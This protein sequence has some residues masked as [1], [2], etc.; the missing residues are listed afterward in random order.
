MARKKN[1]YRI[2][3]VTLFILAAFSAMIFV[4]PPA[5]AADKPIQLK[6][7]SSWGPENVYV[8][9]F[10]I[11]YLK[12]LNETGRVQVTWVGPEA[13]PA[14]EQ[15]Q[16][17][18][19]GLFDMLFTH[20][21]YHIGEIAVGQGMDLFSGSQ[22][23]R[24]EAG[25]YEV[26]DQAYQK[27][28]AKVLGLICGDVGYHLM[29]KKPLN[30]ADFTGLKIR[31]SAT[32]DPLIKSHGGA[33]VR[34]APGEIYSALE[35]GVV[36][37]AAWPVFGALDYKWYE[38]A[39]YQLRPQFGTV[40]EY[41]LINL[42]TWNKLPEDVQKIISQVTMEMED[43]SFIDLTNKWKE[44]EAELVSRGMKLNVLPPAEGEKIIKAFYNRTWDELVLK[45]A[46]E[47]GP[48]LKKLADEFIKK[49]Q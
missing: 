43:Q 1:K 3:I 38:V 49:K 7:L 36:D 20:P 42:D 6:F 19:A 34:L 29:L 37:G 13:V 18:S 5:I 15:L 2:V 30:K 45:H 31:A 25:F 21:A 24:R 47:F 33:T 16:P 14:F 12:K 35:K 39:G 23:E 11:P 8:Q 26:L 9:I 32:Y 27:V 48:K 10:V 44:Q 41:L 17:L 4:G 28:N 40:V 22:K 46:P